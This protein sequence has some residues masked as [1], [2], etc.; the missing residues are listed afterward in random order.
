MYVY[1]G[2]AVIH[3]L[4]EK[5]ADSI[6]KHAKLIICIWIVLLIASVPF[7]YKVLV[8]PEDVLQ[9]DMTTMIDPNSESVRGMVII[10]D[11]NYFYQSDMGTDM[12]LV[13]ECKSLTQ[14]GFIE[15]DFY[16]TL[17]TN[18]F[19][20]YGAD[21]MSVM[22]L[23]FSSKY[24][25]NDGIEM[26]SIAFTDERNSAEEVT[27]I[28]GVISDT[29]AQLYDPEKSYTSLTTYLTGST[30]IGQDTTDSA[31]E[32]VKKIDPF[33]VLLVL[34]LI[35]LF[36]RSLISSATP[37]MT[38]GFAY[39]IVMIVV[40]GLAQLMQVYY[41]TSTLVLVSMLG[42]GCDY[43]IFII[44][45]YREERKEGKDKEGALRESIIWAGESITTSG[46]SVII[47]FGV[48][49]FCSF[50][51]V[52]T[53]GIVLASGIIFALLA[54]LTL[55]PSIL[56][57]VGDKI[58]YPSTVESYKD[59]SRVMQGWY[60]KMSAL[61]RNYFRKSAQLSIKYAKVILVMVILITVPLAYVTL[62]E[63]SS[64]D[65]VSIMPDGE[66][67]NGVN[68]IVENADGG[69][70][71][72]T[73]IL[74]DTGKEIATFTDNYYDLGGGLK[75]G[76]LDWKEMSPGVPYG[77]VYGG[78]TSWSRVGGVVP[79]SI[80]SM[81][82]SSA[83]DNIA[84][85]AGITDSQSSYTASGNSWTIIIN[86][87]PGDLASL[88]KLITDSTLSL[89]DKF[90]A[91]DYL[92]NYNLGAISKC[93]DGRQYVNVS[94][95]VMD[96]PMSELSMKTLRQVED[97][98]E[99]FM[100]TDNAKALFVS[101][102]VTGSVVAIEQISKIV[103]DEFT[104]IEFAVVVLIFILLFFVMRSYF[105]PMRSIITIVMSVVWTL[106]ITHLLFG[107]LLGMPI[108]W[109]VP[110]ILFVI[111]LGLGMDYDILLT[112]RIKENVMKGMS[113]DD[114]IL[115]AVEKSGV[116]ITICGLIMGGAFLTMALSTSPMLMEFGFALGFAILVDA[117]FI[118]TYVVPAVM[119]LMGKW[120]WVGPKFLGGNVKSADASAENDMK[121]A[122]E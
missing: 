111:C 72:P 100:A 79:G 7:V 112:T 46:L 121:Q 119:H 54:A 66:A 5:V 69:M 19:S 27:P 9:Y 14:K 92:L 107:H 26:I 8:K 98:V 74:M 70:L 20:K 71:M 64:Y 22:S 56:M 85:I 95:T 118:R 4:F 21:K 38:I 67:K 6:M 93:V 29:K 88:A 58:F 50:S 52:S 113:N 108:T 78:M 12:I 44:A 105:T 37:P 61:G 31:M 81:I 120:N 62:T 80:A 103:N 75:V 89:E 39:G 84:S 3:M 109:I 101:A 104:W 87:L 117:L 40:Y 13:V 122:G 24:G 42:A 34:V 102:G 28:R 110:I 77:Q 94:V 49:S 23:G 83:F 18:L 60:G 15:N 65:M 99:K 96:Q 91:M 55:I 86:S 53:M 47:G 48:I 41:I 32:D 82:D 57:I 17:K 43:C 76:R 116:V 106:G 73:Y 68:A 25:G 35:G 59:D 33:S 11:P 97:G 51:M 2:L 90:R 115:H 114:A 30:A 1:Y 36:F 45:R 16:N 63:T 10:Q